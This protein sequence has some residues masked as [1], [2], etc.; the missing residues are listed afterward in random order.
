MESHDNPNPVTY[1]L[2]AWLC[3][4]GSHFPTTTPPQPSG[5]THAV[6]LFRHPPP[7]PDRDLVS[8]RSHP[9]SV[10]CRI[11]S[12][13]KCQPANETSNKKGTR[14]DT[15]TRK[16]TKTRPKNPLHPT[17]HQSLLHTYSIPFTASADSSQFA[18]S[19]LIPLSRFNKTVLKILC[20][21]S[22]NPRP[23][24]TRRCSRS[25]TAASTP[26]PPL[27]PSRPVFTRWCS[28]SRVLSA[29]TFV[30]V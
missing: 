8:P 18:S 15:E 22:P 5:V 11:S 6:L 19:A 16:Q 12:K 28:L 23:G 3:S 10:T 21:P 9:L 24:L 29:H 13:S 25:S 14:N 30:P 27:Q 20:P 2:N 17:F 26:Y 4:G 7:R 1:P